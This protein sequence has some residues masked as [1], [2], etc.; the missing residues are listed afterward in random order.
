MKVGA[1]LKAGE[2]TGLSAGYA[3]EYN[4]L[5]P[6][7]AAVGPFAKAAR[8]GARTLFPAGGGET[9][10]QAVAEMHATALAQGIVTEKAGRF[11]R[12]LTAVLRRTRELGEVAGRL[13]SLQLREFPGGARGARLLRASLSMPELQD[14]EDSALKVGL[15]I[16]AK[17]AKSTTPLDLVEV[18]SLIHI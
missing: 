14:G 2:W 5:Q 11:W 18:L 8:A 7:L 16:I 12:E 10:V 3:V 17:L 9:T 15:D 6:Y 4:A 13:E 1:L